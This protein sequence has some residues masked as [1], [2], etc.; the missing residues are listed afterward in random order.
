MKRAIFLLLI[1]L[2]FCSCPPY[3]YDYYSEYQ[4]IL[5]SRTSLENSVFFTG[6]K[7]L[8]EPGKIY[9]KDNF[10]YISEKYQG[11]HIIDNSNPSKPVNI[12]F[13][14]IPGCI[15]MAIKA[16]ILYVDNSV[17][18]V[19]IDLDSQHVTSRNREVFPE[20]LP[21]DRKTLDP[22][23]SSDNRPANSVIVGW[24]KFNKNI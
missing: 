3:E 7:S 24:K 8:E 16:N 20:L 11:V 19:S 15:D 9:F 21:P 12:K 4:P 1:V 10:I 14:S 13:I 22:R 5:M 23:F 18:L 17:D 6:S 2:F